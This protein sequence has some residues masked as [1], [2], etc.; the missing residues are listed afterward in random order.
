MNIHI[1]DLIE[2]GIAHQASDLHLSAG[3]RPLYR[4]DGDLRSYYEHNL[5][6]TEVLKLIESTMNGKQ[7]EIYSRQHEI[8]YTF[9]SVTRQ[10]LRANAFWQQRGA[11]AAFRFISSDIRSVAE[12]ALPACVQQFCE[13]S[14]GLVIVTGATG[15]GKS[16]TLSALIEHINQLQRKHILI[17]EDPIEFIYESK[18]SLIHQR[19]VKRDTESFASALRMAL[20]QDPD[21]ILL[22]EMRDGETIRLT[23]EAAETGHL[24][25]ATLHAP[26]AVK[27]IDRIVQ[28]FSGE[29]Q[30]FIRILLSTTLRAVISQELIPRKN[31]GRAAVYEIMIV[32]P[33]VSNLIREN[34]LMQ[35]QSVIQT[36]QALGM[37]TRDQG[38]QTFNLTSAR[39]F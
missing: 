26:S 9:E 2:I 25:L 18:L 29:E 23:L 8:D 38:H 15:S 28:I 1:H 31:G 13:Y 22:G 17:I 11:G 27:T 33:A 7:M 36:G 14:N 12:L 16:T 21:V 32:T 34:K 20:R 6:H 10:R 24:V 5:D 37:Q 30:S 39:H 4:V 19:E 35:I 3:C